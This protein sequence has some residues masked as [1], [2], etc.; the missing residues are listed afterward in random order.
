MPPLNIGILKFDILMVTNYI[1]SAFI[2][3]LQ[4]SD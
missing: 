3:Q 2:E 4:L 1:C